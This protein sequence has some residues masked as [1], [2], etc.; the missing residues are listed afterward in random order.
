MGGAGSLVAASWPLLPT[1]AIFGDQAALAAG[2]S[3]SPGPC[4]YNSASGV[5][6]TKVPVQTQSP[7]IMV[8]PN[9]GRGIVIIR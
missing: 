2:L 9:V 8:L 1:P 6:G 3:Q 5:G 7:I 4:G